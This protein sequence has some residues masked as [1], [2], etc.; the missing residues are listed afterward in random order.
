MLQSMPQRDAADVF[1]RIR[2]GANAEAVVQ[3]VQDGNLIMELSV[4]PEPSSR[5]H[6]P[7]LDKIPSR[8]QNSTYFRSQIYEAIEASEKPE[9]PT[10]AHSTLQRSNYEKPLLAA[11]LIEP[12]LED[13]KPLNWTTVSSNDHLLR[14]LLEEYFL[15]QYS[16]QFFFHKNYFLEDMAS[17]GTEFCSPLLVNAILAKACVS[18]YAAMAWMEVD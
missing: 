7:Y 9:Q 12:L 17:R 16:G 18:E 15:N 13:T 1:R 10:H 2:A 8:L 11:K 4:V 14:A 6:F 5:Y 3:H